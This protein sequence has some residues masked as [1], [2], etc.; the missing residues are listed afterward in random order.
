MFIAFETIEWS[1]GPRTCVG[2]H[3]SLNGAKEM[4]ER[5]FADALKRDGVSRWWN[6]GVCW[7]IEWRRMG[8]AVGMARDVV[9]QGT[10]RQKKKAPRIVW[11]DWDNRLEHINKSLTLEEVFAY[12]LLQGDPVTVDALND[13]LKG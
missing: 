13:I 2:F 8:W 3:P 10:I 6:S 1:G 5:L 4:V 7:V 9:S 11:R 12:N